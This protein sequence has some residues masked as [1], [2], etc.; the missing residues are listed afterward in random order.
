MKTLSKNKKQNYIKIFNFLCMF[1]SCDYQITRYDKMY[2]KCHKMLQVYSNIMHPDIS[3]GVENKNIHT[4][5]KIISQSVE[6]K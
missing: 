3:V 1:G 4:S 5:S 6:F 2:L